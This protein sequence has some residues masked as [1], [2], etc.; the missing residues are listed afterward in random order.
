MRRTIAPPALAFVLGAA[1]YLPSLTH[2]YVW[3]DRTLIAENRFLADAREIGRNLTSDFFRRSAEPSQIGHWRPV[4][5]A[6]YMADRRT[7]GGSALAF[8]LTNVLLHGAAA[9][10]VAALAVSLGLPASAALL[11]AALFATHP[12]HVESVAWISGRTDLLCAVF[13]LT[14]MTIDARGGPRWAGALATLLSVASKEMAVAVPAAVALRALWLPRP[15]ERDVSS[16]RA[17]WRAAWPHLAAIALYALVRFGA[18]GLMPRAPAAAGA[19]RVALFW[20]WWSA[21]AEYARVLVWPFPLSIVSPV[22]LV[23]SPWSWRV[24]AGIVLAGAIAALA[25][26][27]RHLR[28]AVSWGLAAFLA[29]LVPLVNFVVPVRAIGSVAFPWAERFLY[30]PSI[31]LCVAAAAAVAALRPRAR[32]VATAAVVAVACAFAA[33]TLARE[34]VWASQRSLFAAAVREHPE[35]A[36]ARVNLAAALLD[37]GDAAGAEAQLDRALATSPDDPIA[38]YL[39]GNARRGRGDPAAA[40]ASYRRALSIRPVYPQA[41]INLGLVLAARGDLDGAEASFREADGQLGGAPETKVNLAIVAR[42]RGRTAEA[43]ALYR[44]ALALDPAFAPA[45]EGLASLSP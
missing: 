30:V 9:A 15:G 10:L 3:D 41:L 6:S 34:R 32:A 17:A 16:G 39:R 18:L 40:E 27:R 24:A 37:S 36:P 14:A 29:S 43:A 1:L 44:E 21:L 45:R 20:T 7:G 5:T 28:P 33:R 42:L 38:L 11:A 12:V 13:A 19:G 22:T 35:D 2:G 26:S 25:W 8:H 23:S 31:F 4:V